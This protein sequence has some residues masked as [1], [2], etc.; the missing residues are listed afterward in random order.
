[1]MSNDDERVLVQEVSVGN[2]AVIDKANPSTDEA[3]EIIAMRAAERRYRPAYSGP[4]L[5]NGEGD[6]EG[7]TWAAMRKWMYD[8]G[9]RTFPWHLTWKKQPE[10]LKVEFWRQLRKEFPH[11]WSESNVDNYV[12]IFENFLK[13]FCGCSCE[14]MQYFIFPTGRKLQNLHEIGLQMGSHF[15]S[16]K[17]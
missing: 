3:V 6:E 7:K 17:Y 15:R 13:Y 14:L 1:M 10:K 8:V 11:H 5:T 16:A 9:I 4:I 12:S 2:H